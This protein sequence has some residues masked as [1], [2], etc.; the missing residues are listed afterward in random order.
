M[1]IYKCGFV[2]TPS[3]NVY[4]FSLSL[5]S[6][7]PFRFLIL[8]CSFTIHN[9]KIP[10]TL[11][12][13]HHLHSILLKSIPT[14]GKIVNNNQST[15]YGTTSRTLCRNLTSEMLHPSHVSSEFGL[16]ALYDS[17]N[18]GGDVWINENC[19]R[20]VRQLGEDACTVSTSLQSTAKMVIPLLL[21]FTLRYFF[22]FILSYF[23]C[24]FSVS[25]STFQE[26]RRV[27]QINYGKEYG[28]LVVI[29]DVID[30]NRALI[31]APDMVRS[32][33]NF[34]RLSLT[35]IKIDIKRVPKKKGLVKAMEDML[36]P[37]EGRVHGAGNS[38]LEREGHPS[39]ILIVND[40]VAH[41]ETEMCVSLYC[42]VNGRGFNLCIC[43]ACFGTTKYCHAWLIN[44]PCS[45]PDCLYLH[46]IGSRE[47]SFTKYEI[48][49]VYT[50]FQLLLKNKAKDNDSDDNVDFVAGNVK[51]IT[52]K[53]VWDQYLEEARKDGKIV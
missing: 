10:K 37:S 26:I 9:F 20:I 48:I 12:L 18:G 34:K 1:I 36:R 25:C 51:L 19:F 22:S 24:V 7:Q 32:Q 41:A 28:M 23:N 17:V 49:S 4:T 50:R 45:N 2:K 42:Y 13:I 46:E 40:L 15:P 52:T 47:D 39:M 38:L 6:V 5:G 33:V 44:M 35:D 31:D 11:T 29:V 43:R 3:L 14:I 30:H 8:T 21:F 27:A 53:E 16:N